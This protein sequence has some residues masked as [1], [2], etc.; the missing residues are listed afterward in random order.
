LRAKKGYTSRARLAVV[1]AMRAV[2]RL[3]AAALAYLQVAHVAASAGES[4][5][6][7]VMVYGATV[8]KRRGAACCIRPAPDCRCPRARLPADSVRF[9]S[10]PLRP[11]AASLRLPH[12]AAAR[13]A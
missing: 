13:G 4:V 6:S 9:L 11:P 3:L 5:S 2:V 8:S 12:A 7:D 10:A 1:T